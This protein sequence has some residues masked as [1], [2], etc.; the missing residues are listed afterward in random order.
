M[1]ET[2]DGLAMY[3][4]VVKCVKDQVRCGVTIYS[5][6]SWP[7]RRSSRRGK[8]SDGVSRDVLSI[9]TADERLDART[10]D[11]WSHHGTEIVTCCCSDH[12]AA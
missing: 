9:S 8:S 7:L 6:S 3:S 1:L 12:C 11:D 2:M 4:L 10:G 5:Y